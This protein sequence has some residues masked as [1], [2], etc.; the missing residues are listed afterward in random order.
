MLLGQLF[1]QE[2]SGGFDDDI[3]VDFIPLQVGR[4][5]F[6]GQADLVAV[7]DEVVA[8][9]RDVGLELAV[10]RIILQHVGEIL[11]I[12]QVVDADDLDVLAEILDRSPE[13]HPADPAETVDANSDHFDF[14]FFD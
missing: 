9:D 12:E 3:G 8:L 6:R 13:D 7:D 1:G 5:L 4:A 11:G 2:E 10:D 14:P